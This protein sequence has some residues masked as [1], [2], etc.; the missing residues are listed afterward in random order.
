MKLTMTN[1]SRNTAK[2]REVSSVVFAAAK[3]A[4][5]DSSASAPLMRERSAPGDHP[6]RGKMA[7]SVRVEET[8][9]VAGVSA[10]PQRV[11]RVTMV[12][13]VNATMNT[14]RSSRI[15]YV[16]ETVNATV[17]NVNATQALR[18]QPVSV[19]CLRRAVLPL[20]TLCAMAEGAASV[21]AVSVRRDT[22]VHDVRHAWAALTLA[23]PK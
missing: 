6:V 15:N 22:S 18:V 12:T 3:R 16:E 17:V 1:V 14:V 8:V 13:T 7:L 23:R 20:T 21:T 10:T 2:A 4:L 9:C 5:S 11:E 19:R